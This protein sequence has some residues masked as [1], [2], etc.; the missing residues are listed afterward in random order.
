MID[1]SSN[2][3]IVRRWAQVFP[4]KIRLYTN[5]T[6]NLRWVHIFGMPTPDV[7][8]CSPGFSFSSSYIES[9][10][11]NVLMEATLNPQMKKAHPPFSLSHPPVQ[12]IADTELVGDVRQVHVVVIIINEV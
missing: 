2:L 12:L 10:I 11:L 6:M 1:L 7:L 9:Y 3:L 8:R 5:S 4:G